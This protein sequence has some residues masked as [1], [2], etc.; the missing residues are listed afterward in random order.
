MIK[1]TKITKEVTI[2]HRYCDVCGAQLNWELQCS[3]A[4][5]EMCGKD[6]CNKCVGKEN[7]TMGDYREVYCKVCWKIGEPYIQAIKEHEEAIDKL[8]DEW[9]KKCHS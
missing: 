5:C 8:N 1:E 3:V 2:K 7:G 4:Q 6:L 9:S